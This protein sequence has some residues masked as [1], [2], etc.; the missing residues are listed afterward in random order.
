MFAA[1]RTP[2]TRAFPFAGRRAFS[3]YS[4][5]GRTPASPVKVNLEIHRQCDNKLTCIQPA[6][7]AVLG[8]AG[9]IGQPLSLLLK[10]SPYV[11]NLTLYDIRGAPG[12]P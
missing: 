8:A 3:D 4:P 12:K 7:V 5:F 6:K 2:A 11:T 10:L 9:G 1:V